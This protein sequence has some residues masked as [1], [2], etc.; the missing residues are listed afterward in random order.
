MMRHLM[1][2]HQTY[3]HMCRVWVWLEAHWGPPAPE[4]PS[5]QQLAERRAAGTAANNASLLH[6]LD[7]RTRHQLSEAVSKSDAGSKA[8]LAAQLNA[9][10]QETLAAARRVVQAA[11]QTGHHASGCDA[12]PAQVPAQ[13]LAEQSVKCG[14]CESQAVQQPG[15][16]SIE[17]EAGSGSSAEATAVPELK[18]VLLQLETAFQE[19]CRVSGVS[20]VP[21]I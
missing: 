15:A 17:P 10:R 18:G 4:P 5:E 6:G 9:A 7:L 16:G 13:P 20:T 1:P 3:L 14:I 2:L 8:R 21:A 11:Q 12:C 19:L